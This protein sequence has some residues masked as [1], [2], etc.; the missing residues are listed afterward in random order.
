MYCTWPEKSFSWKQLILAILTCLEGLGK[1]AV[2]SEV[3][4]FLKPWKS[5]APDE[6]WVHMT[7]GWSMSLVLSLNSLILLPRQVKNQE[8]STWIC[9]DTGKKLLGV[10]FCR[11]QEVVLQDFSQIPMA[12]KENTSR[13][14]EKSLGQFSSSRDYVIMPSSFRQLYITASHTKYCLSCRLQKNT[15]PIFRKKNYV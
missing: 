5:R 12:R 7:C 3:T 9:R 15:N 13:D 1:E 11:L 2:G 8:C 10:F 6:E 14:T 4:Y